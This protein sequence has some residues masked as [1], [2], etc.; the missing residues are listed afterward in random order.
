MLMTGISSASI[1][2]FLPP[3]LPFSPS[4]LSLYLPHFA[5]QTNNQLTSIE[6]GAFTNLTNLMYLNLV[7]DAGWTFHPITPPTPHNR[8]LHYFTCP[9]CRVTIFWEATAKRKV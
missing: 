6:A 4:S 7:R 1:I 3:Y 5:S 9:I 8:H 2:V